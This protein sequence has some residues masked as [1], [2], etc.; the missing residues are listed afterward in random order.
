MLAVLVKNKARIKNGFIYIL[1]IILMVFTIRN[2]TNLF[3]D[4]VYSY[5]LANH[6]EGMFMQIEDGKT[7]YPS[8][9]PWISY[10]AVDLNNRFDYANVWENQTQDV[11]PPLYYVVLHT[12]CS[13]FPGSV[14]KWFAG[15]VN[16]LFALGTLYILRKLMFV[17]VQDEAVQTVVS[18]G[19]VCCAGVLSAVSFLRMYII[20][21]FWVTALAYVF[22]R[23][24]GER[25]TAKF[26]FML[27]LCTLGGALTHYYC[28]VYA[29]FASVVYGIYLL[30]K[31]RLKETGFFCLAQA[32]AGGLSVC[33]FPAMLHHIFSSA[34]GE[35][36]AQNMENASLAD[37][38]DR[39]KTYFELLDGQLFGG[40]FIYI[41]LT[42]LILLFVCGIRGLKQ[43]DLC[44]TGEKETVAVRWLSL[45]VPVVL[46]FILI[47][48]IAVYLSDRYMYP[49]YAVLFVAVS[50]GVACWAKHMAGKFSIYVIISM[51]AVMSVN[52]WHNIGWVYLFLPSEQ[53]LEQ[54]AAYGDVDCIY[55]YEKP[56]ETNPA[57]YEASRYHSITFFTP[58]D[59]EML[60]SSDIASRYQLIVMVTGDDENIL[61]KIREIC[62]ELIECE[63]LGGYGYTDTYYLHT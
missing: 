48:K 11:H 15:L 59:L 6:T 7:Y 23:Q 25:H 33:I 20:A 24:I 44:F 13:L 19:F 26:Y 43:P 50:C 55:I 39:V 40:I 12:I 51:T 30:Y 32:A 53:L 45:V 37:L 10:M 54:A 41:A 42:A 28:I 3:V 46:Y 38:A 63:H 27:M 29:V 61:G 49:V 22:I 8:N 36:S 47:A 2:K 35:E 4:E 34:R 52:S 60:E 56:W 16:I 21:M 9:A 62:P 57:Y 58:D 17:L 31:K 5:G 18:I 14:S 1:F